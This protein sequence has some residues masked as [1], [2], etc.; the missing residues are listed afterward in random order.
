MSRYTA[1][2]PPAEVAFS[3]G[4][5]EPKINTLFVIN[6]VVNFVFFIDMVRVSPLIVSPLP[7]GARLPVVPSVRRSC[8]SSST[9][10][11]QSTR[12]RCGSDRTGRS[13][14]GTVSYTHLTLPTK[15]IV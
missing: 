11:C 1:L 10:S 8:S 14:C 13:C 6:Q 5:E 15:R 12:G 9:C 2:V 4:K 7:P 3:T